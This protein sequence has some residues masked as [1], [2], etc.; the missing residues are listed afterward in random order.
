MDV[1][2]ERR[3]DEKLDALDARVD[4]VVL[5]LRELRMEMRAGFDRTH[6]LMCLNGVLLVALVAALAA[7]P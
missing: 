5:S 6:R 2:P 7:Q 4:R 3:N 1:M